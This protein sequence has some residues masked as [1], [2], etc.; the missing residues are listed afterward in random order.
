MKVLIRLACVLGLT[1]LG[2]CTPA[3]SSVY[4]DQRPP[5]ILVPPQAANQQ[6]VAPQPYVPQ[7]YV[8]PQQQY[9][10]QGPRTVPPRPVQA[11]PQP[12]VQVPAQPQAQWS[13]P[14]QAAPP[15]QRPLNSGDP[16]DAAV[17]RLGSGDAVRIEVL[18]ETELSMEALID[19]SGLINYPFLGTVQAAGNTVRELELKIRNG[20]RGGYLVNPDVRVGLARYRP[21]FISGQVRAPGSY[22]YSLGLNVEKAITLAGGV[23]PFGS[24]SRVYRQRNGTSD[25]DRIKVTLDSTVLPGDYIIVEERL[26]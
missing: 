5:T 20:L 21:V 18:G 4:V 15:V 12:P 24:T 23:T 17:Y 3:P 13:A 11:R 9:A 26:F 1:G 6:Y 2:A 19:P 16:L 22:P 8:Q 7:P 25:D 10:Q 14:Q